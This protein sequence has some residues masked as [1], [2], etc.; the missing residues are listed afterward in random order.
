MAGSVE[1]HRD[2]PTVI[3]RAIGLPPT[4]QEQVVA[5]ATAAAAESVFDLEW[6]TAVVHTGT[7]EPEPAS[8]FRA[9]GA[10]KAAP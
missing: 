4:E 9:A 5:A 10:T 8:T 6:G 1:A 7:G 3:S 2:I